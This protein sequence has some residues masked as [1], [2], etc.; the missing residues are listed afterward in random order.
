MKETGVEQLIS[1]VS[2]RAGIDEGSAKTAVE[3]VLG[4]LKDKLPEPI[5][6]QVEKVAAGGDVDP[7]SM[8]GGLFGR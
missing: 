7:G 3:T 5:A 6:S 4:F 2:Q 1:L 8:L